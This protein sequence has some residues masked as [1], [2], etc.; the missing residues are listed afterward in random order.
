M[1]SKINKL[2]DIYFVEFLYAF[3]LVI[4]FFMQ[5]I[6]IKVF[7][8][9]SVFLLAGIN[10]SVVLFILFY[11]IL[12]KFYYYLIFLSLLSLLYIGN[13]F[14]YVMR[15]ELLLNLPLYV[16]FISAVSRYLSKENFYKL[17]LS[18]F[19]RL[20]LLFVIYSVISSLYGYFKGFEID[21]V[22]MEFYHIF[23][24]FFA[25]VFFYIFKERRDYLVVV[26]FLIVIFVFISLGHIALYLIS[27]GA[28]FVSYQ[29]NFTPM[30]IGICF[31]YF[32]ITE[33][34]YKKITSF[35]VLFFLILGTFLTLTRGLW[36]ATVLVMVSVTLIHVYSYKKQKSRAVLLL[37]IVFLFSVVLMYGDSGKS[38]SSNTE[39]QSIEYRS[40]SILSPTQDISFLMRVDFGYSTIVKFISS[41]IFGTGIGDKLEYTIFKAASPPKSY[42]DNSWFY[43]LWKQGIIGTILFL[44]VY[45]RFFKQSVYVYKNTS[46]TIIRIIC[47]GI[48]AGMIGTFFNSMLT[49]VLIKYKLNLLFA[50]LF[51]FVEFESRKII[52]ENH[53]LT[54]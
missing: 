45:I 22:F 39:M 51:A 42:P 52:K 17:T 53:K 5:I 9:K 50:F 20:L 43:F 29:S 14:H 21:R 24:Y 10:V 44:L 3:I 30:I 33:K 2:V 11:K 8:E 31:S 48:V 13:E 18:R 4:N 19:Q 7:G 47:I 40:Q 49:A 25:F 34:T 12:P 27:G 28:R 38:Q 32:L 1:I 16:I 37:S 46:S 26:K 54:F 35:I 6:F 23:Y 36:V 15:I 41:P